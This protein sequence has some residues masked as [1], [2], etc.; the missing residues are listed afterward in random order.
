[1]KLIVV[2]SIKEHQEQVA[3]LLHGVGINRFSVIDMVGYKKKAKDLG[4]YSISSRNAK[5]NS[6]LLFS[7]TSEELAEKAL[8]EVSSCNIDTNNPYP[9]HAFILDVEQFSNFL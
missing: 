9:V 2:V 1:M 8:A 7:F 5:T 3:S 6:I 4:W